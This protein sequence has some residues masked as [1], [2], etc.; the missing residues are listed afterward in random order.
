MSYLPMFPIPMGGSE[1]PD[2][3]AA[4]SRGWPSFP[5]PMGGSEMFK[6]TQ[7]HADR[8]GRSRSPWGVVSMW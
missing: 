4:W 1:W 5:I 3:P 2:M 7:G 8:H 6:L